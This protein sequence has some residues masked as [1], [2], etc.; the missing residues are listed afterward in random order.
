MTVGDDGALG[1]AI[2]VDM[3][4]ARPAIE[5]LAIN[6]KPSVETLG[7]HF[8]EHCVEQTTVFS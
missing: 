1:P 5:A 8:F 6:C 2:R 7:S 4:A 3:K